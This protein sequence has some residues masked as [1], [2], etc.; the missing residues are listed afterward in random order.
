MKEP[1]IKN[2]QTLHVVILHRQSID[3][4]SDGRCLPGEH[5]SIMF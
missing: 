5:H 3:D 4:W 2:K 1:S